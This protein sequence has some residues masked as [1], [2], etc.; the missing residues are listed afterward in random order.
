[1]RQ[2]LLTPAKSAAAS[3]LTVLAHGLQLAARTAHQGAAL[4]RPP[5]DG[6]EAE[7]ALD[8]LDGAVGGPEGALRPDD[9]RERSAAE[10]AA[11]PATRPARHV[12]PG[13]RAAQEPVGEP[14]RRPPTV[15]ADLASRPVREVTAEIDRLPPDELR[16]LRE[17]EQ[18]GRQRKTVLE[19]IDRALAAR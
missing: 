2:D 6:D 15:V 1:M 10:A 14:A 13:A 18:A 17:H 12:E 16:R 19:A 9:A 5:S 8:R 3:A 11:A 4:L 7:R